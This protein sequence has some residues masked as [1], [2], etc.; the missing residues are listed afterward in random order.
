M[1]CMYVMLCYV[2]YKG[3]GKGKGG[4]GGGGGVTLIP[5]RRV[6]FILDI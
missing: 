4:G 1:L 3:K 2:M 5:L 6:G